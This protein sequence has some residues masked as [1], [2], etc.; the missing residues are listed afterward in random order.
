[1]LDF[2]L[3]EEKTIQI[4]PLHMYTLVHLF[5]SKRKESKLGK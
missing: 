2:F 4:L 1:M 5:E 3:L